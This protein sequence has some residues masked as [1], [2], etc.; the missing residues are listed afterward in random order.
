MILKKYITYDKIQGNTLPMAGGGLL[1]G[2]DCI[3]FAICFCVAQA[4]AV[5][6]FISSMYRLMTYRLEFYDTDVTK[7]IS[8]RVLWDIVLHSTSPVLYNYTDASH[9]THESESRLI[10]KYMQTH[11]DRIHLYSGTFSSRVI[12]PGKIEE[13]LQK[14]VASAFPW[15][16]SIESLDTY[17]LIYSILVL[18]FAVLFNNIHTQMKDGKGPKA[19][20]KVNTTHINEELLLYD[21]GYWFLLLMAMFITIDATSY[22]SVSAITGWSA[23]VYVSTLYSAC[24]VADIGSA[25]RVITTLSWGVA[26]LMITFVTNASLFDGSFIILIHLINAIFMYIQLAEGD[27]TY[28]KFV[29]LRIWSVVAINVCLL[30]TYI[31]N[32]SYIEPTHENMRQQT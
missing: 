31:N 19:D 27:I 9:S 3:K 2:N 23:L 1:A 32:I 11:N 17:M 25:S 22:V 29:N 12:F 8:I 30:I 14:S 4:M 6:F 5:A 7:I 24:M 20:E 26:V 21:S 16:L 18:L 10:E 28:V 13:V 15:K